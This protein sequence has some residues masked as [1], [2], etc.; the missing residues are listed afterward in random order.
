MMGAKGVVDTVANYGATIVAT[1]T[2]K[3]TDTT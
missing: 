2:F 3:T 1:E